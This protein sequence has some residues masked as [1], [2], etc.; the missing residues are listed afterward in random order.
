[1]QEATA[2]DANAAY[3]STHGYLSSLGGESGP[4]PAAAVQK[5]YMW[6]PEACDA[7]PGPQ[8]ETDAPHFWLPS[9][10]SSDSRE[11]LDDGL[12]ASQ[13]RKGKLPSSVSKRSKNMDTCRRSQDFA[14]YELQPPVGRRISDIVVPPPPALEALDAPSQ[15]V[16]HL[17]QELEVP[18]T[19]LQLLEAKGL[20]AQIPFNEEGGL[21]SV[22]SIDHAS[23]NCSPC[24][25][26]FKGMCAHSLMCRHCHLIHP[27]QKSKR[28]RPSKQTRQRMRNLRV[29]T[30]TN[31][32]D[33]SGT[34]EDAIVEQPHSLS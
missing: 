23:G 15:L 13:G 7:G 24:A 17:H 8:S 6:Q 5:S 29:A 18:L 22:G 10:S 33:P 30:G 32:R 25:Y 16:L 31:H 34:D 11:S 1:M 21:T 26:W 4:W 12:Q 20:L 14:R 9:L 27:G 28:L 3:W 19:D 2:E